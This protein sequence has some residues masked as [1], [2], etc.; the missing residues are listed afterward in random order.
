MVLCIFILV[1]TPCGREQIVGEA[2]WEKELPAAQGTQGAAGQGSPKTDSG[3][4][5]ARWLSQQCLWQASEDHRENRH[6]L[7]GS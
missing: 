1:T 2:P 4:S 3:I 6:H 7:P 5:S